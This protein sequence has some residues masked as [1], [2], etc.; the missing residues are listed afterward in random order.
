MTP[1]QTDAGAGAQLH[2]ERNVAHGASGGRER[3]ELAADED[4]RRAGEEC[5]HTRSAATL[6]T[7]RL[8]GATGP[9]RG[10][11]LAASRGST[12]ETMLA[13]PMPSRQREKKKEDEERCGGCATRIDLERR[14]MRNGDDKPAD[15]GRRRGRIGR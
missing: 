2:D 15:T 14:R 9:G 13:R 7:V 3:P 8:L 6:H 1:L 4:E 5:S 12:A 10:R 11:G